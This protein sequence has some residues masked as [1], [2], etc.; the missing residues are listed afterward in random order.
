MTTLEK[1][2]EAMQHMQEAKRLI[3]EAKSENYSLEKH[4]GY[5]LQI[6]SQEL[7]RFSDN[8]A[9][10]LG[11]NTNLQEIINAEGEHWE[12]EPINLK[13]KRGNKGNSSSEGGLSPSKG[14][15]RH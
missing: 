7:V 13:R 6:I 8:R 4:Y 11:R 9:G 14:P 10:Y 2:E 5:S 15:K 3:F 12:S 1:L